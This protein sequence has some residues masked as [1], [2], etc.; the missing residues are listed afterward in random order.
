MKAYDEKKCLLGV[1]TLY[2]LGVTQCQGQKCKIL[3][4]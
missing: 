2:D 4:D 3:T 1:L